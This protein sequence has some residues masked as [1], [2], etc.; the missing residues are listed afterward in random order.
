MIDEADEEIKDPEILKVGELYDYRG[1]FTFEDYKYSGK[2][3]GHYA[4]VVSRNIYKNGKYDYTLLYKAHDFIDDAI[5]IL[6]LLIQGDI[7]RMDET[8]SVWRYVRKKG[9]GNWNS[10]AMERNLIRDDCYLSQ[11]VT[12]WLE[13]YRE[14]SEYGRERAKKDF[15]IALK[16]YL[17]SP[18]KENKKFLKDMYDYNIKELVCKGKKTS[19][20]TY[21]L[22]C[23]W[24]SLFGKKS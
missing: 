18:G 21:S 1:S 4:T 14:I 7:Y 5:I 9:G 2:W 16:M 12:K 6:L 11:Y 10:L 19:L 8:M 3:P 23:M 13:N 15:K 20:F 24:E 22:G 17:K